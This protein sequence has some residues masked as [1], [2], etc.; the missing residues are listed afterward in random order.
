[1]L[2]DPKIERATVIELFLELSAEGKL[3]QWKNHFK[4]CEALCDTVAFM[5]K[6]DCERPLQILRMHV[7]NRLLLKQFAPLYV[8]MVAAVMDDIELS[9]F[10]FRHRFD[11]SD[12]MPA[13]TVILPEMS[14]GVPPL[15]LVSL[16]ARGGLDSDSTWPYQLWAMVSADFLWAASRA[17]NKAWMSQTVVNTRNHQPCSHGYGAYKCSGCVA[18][19]KSEGKHDIDVDIAVEY[20]KAI[21]EVKKVQGTKQT[22]QAA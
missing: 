14:G 12:I 5:R 8:F 6:Y 19:D 10:A 15:D 1:M 22:S 3:L 9:A 20:E 11:A 21:D 18:K 13:G 16:N 7:L 17:W 2:P 4:M